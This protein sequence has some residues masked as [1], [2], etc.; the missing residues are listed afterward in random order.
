MSIIRTQPA[1]TVVDFATV[2]VGGT[3]RWNLAVEIPPT[4][5]VADDG[6][7]VVV[8]SLSRGQADEAARKIN[9]A[10]AR[11]IDEGYFK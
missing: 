1:R 2:E 9:E 7:V 11:W 8:S 4:G 3:G 5:D 10:L 6:P